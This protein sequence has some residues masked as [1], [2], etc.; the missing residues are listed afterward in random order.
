MIGFYNYTVILTYL[1]LASSVSGILLLY[2]DPKL[3]PV[4]VGLLL[5]SGLCDMFDG[6][7]A[8]MKKRTSMEENFGGQ[9]D[10]LSDMVC[11]GIFPAV[12]GYFLAGEQVWTIPF[13][14]VFVLCGLIRLAYFDVR[15]IEKK[16][17]PDA[18]ISNDYLGLPITCAALL[19]PLLF[20]IRPLYFLFIG[21]ENALGYHI[22]VVVAM[23]MTA[24]AF[25]TPFRIKKA[26]KKG[27]CCLIIFGLLLVV[28][29]IIGN[30]AY[31]NSLT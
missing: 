14:V 1:S 2:H 27:V 28:A 30:I 7:V 15:S 16:Y 9:I 31:Q 4:S 17:N 5:F 19:S 29:A 13:L 11:F 3:L 22:F 8:R 25:V 10:S 12:I 21:E 18:G 20:A 26:G 23:L 6:R 24:T